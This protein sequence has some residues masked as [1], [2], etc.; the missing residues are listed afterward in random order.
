[1]VIILE[2]P[3]GV[4]KTTQIELLRAHYEAQ[5]LRVAVT[6]PRRPDNVP[7]TPIAALYTWLAEVARV[8]EVEI[9]RLLT[10]HDVVLVDRLHL[11]TLV[12]QYEQK[13]RGPALDN[14]PTGVVV[15]FHELLTATD[16][17]YVIVELSHRSLT[18]LR[19]RIVARDN[20]DADFRPSDQISY[21]H[22]RRWHVRRVNYVD[23]SRPAQDVADRIIQIADTEM[24]F[25]TPVTDRRT[26]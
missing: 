2:G 26:S 21:E 8:A 22:A 6:A 15:Q 16:R 23:A 11:S 4:G 19:D 18:E 7:S 13:L 14:I 12:Y 20:S 9:P 10:D 5:G 17:P 1:V 25:F 24:S 3:D